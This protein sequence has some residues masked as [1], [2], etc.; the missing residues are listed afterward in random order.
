MQERDKAL[1]PLPEDQAAILFWALDV[2][3]ARGNYARAAEIQKQLEELGW[4]VTR[5]RP[6]PTA[7]TNPPLPGR[8]RRGDL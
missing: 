5:R 2:A 7:T 4:V 8:G 3:Q 6:R 1:P